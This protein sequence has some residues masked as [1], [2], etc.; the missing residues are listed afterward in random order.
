MNY[1]RLYGEILRLGWPILVAQ[2]GGI[3]TGMAD[4]LMVGHYST[5]ALASASFVN[6]VFNVTIFCIIGFSYGVT[7]LA[8]ALWG[9][10]KKLSIG[11]LVRRALRLNI[12]FSLV[13]TGLMTVLY[14]NLDFLGQPAELMGQIR[15]YY[16]TQLCA[17]VG[18]AMFNV[19][20]QWSYAV[21]NTK[22]PTVIVIAGQVLNIFGNWLLIYGVWGCPEMGLLGAG[23]STLA[24]RWLCV[25]A[26]VWVFFG[27]KANREYVRGWR[28]RANE[29]GYRKIFTTSLPV[30]LQMTFESGSFTVCAIMVG[31]LGT[32]P[33]A[34][35]QIFIITGTLGFCVY[36][37]FGAAVSILVANATGRGEAAQTR[38]TAWA[39][40]HVLMTIMVLSS[41]VLLAW[42]RPIMGIFSDDP[43]VQMAAWAIIIPLVLYQGADA[44]QLNFSNAL[45]GTSHVMPMLWVALISYVFIGIPAAYLLGFTA[46]MGL[47][48]IALSFSTSLLSAA[49]L[50]WLAFMRVTR[51]AT[52]L[53]AAS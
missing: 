29:L 18:C 40:L 12:L 17:M 5:E 33:L 16:I 22:M 23:I 3:A 4:T 48:G 32:V 43:A 42:G 25:A 30:S 13:I 2:L 10:G 46:E 49:I 34:A 41:I 15:P 28:T 44:V 9:Q 50:Y 1:R 24:A 14:F 52:H 11:A 31:W 35:Y 20:C 47:Y 21:R 45:R 6:N 53:T 37:G 38:Q 36:Y 7:P 51:S 8:G 39:G 19:M 26:I 27:L